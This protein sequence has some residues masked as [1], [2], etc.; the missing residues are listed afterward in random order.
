MSEANSIAGTVG[1]WVSP[2]LMFVITTMV[3]YMMSH[4]TTSTSSDTYR[5]NL[6]RQTAV[7]MA[8]LQESNK[9]ILE[10]LL[11]IERKP[12]TIQIESGDMLVL[13][14]VPRSSTQ[15]TGAHIP[16]QA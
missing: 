2:F 7:E 5:N 3:A 11:R 12:Q 8:L 4:I 16:R 9:A 1:T 10:V 14:C 6:L 15:V 13:Q